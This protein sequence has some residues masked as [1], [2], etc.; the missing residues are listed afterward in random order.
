MESKKYLQCK[1]SFLTK[2]N[3]H[4]YFAKKGKCQ[5]NSHSF[6]LKTYWTLY[7]LPCF[8]KQYKVAIIWEANM[9]RG[10]EVRLGNIQPSVNERNKF[11][12]RSKELVNFQIKLE[13][14][15]NNVK[16]QLFCSIEPFK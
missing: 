1:S 3:L 8:T 11:H 15:S 12:L 13:W 9:P 5:R 4:V 10:Y 7:S 6:R 14:L 2:C 16:S